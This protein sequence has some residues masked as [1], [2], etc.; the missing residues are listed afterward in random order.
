MR[1]EG[2]ERALVTPHESRRAFSA[3]AAAAA[4]GAIGAELPEA[5]NV[6]GLAPLHHHRRF[7][8]RRGREHRVHGVEHLVRNVS[9]PRA[10]IVLGNVVLGGHAP[11]FSRRAI[12]P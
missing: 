3:A 8:C 10:H 5:E 11:S 4:A 1:G 6:R 7:R 12:A 2:E 9:D